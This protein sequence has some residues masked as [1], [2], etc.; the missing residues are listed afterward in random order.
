[1]EILLVQPTNSRII[2]I[3]NRL[4][5]QRKKEK[6]NTH[7]NLQ[8]KIITFFLVIIPFLLVERN[9]EIMNTSQDISQ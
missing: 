4:E 5:S 7:M 2:F 8:K 1:M 3:I 9:R 6:H